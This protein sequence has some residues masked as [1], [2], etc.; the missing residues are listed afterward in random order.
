MLTPSQE[1]CHY[2]RED[3]LLKPESISAHPTITVFKAS[4]LSEVLPQQLPTVY[5]VIWPNW[6]W[7]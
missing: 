3:A 1:Y 4:G 5:F 6:E 7:Q 2:R